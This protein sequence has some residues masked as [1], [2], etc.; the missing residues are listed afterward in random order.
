MKKLAERNDAISSG[1][2]TN[3]DA[4]ELF[5]WIDDSYFVG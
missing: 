3:I 5:I 4:M 2:M 1:G